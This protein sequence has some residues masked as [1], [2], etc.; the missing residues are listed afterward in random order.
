M[1]ISAAPAATDCS[2]SAMRRGRG[3]RPAGKPVE[4]AATGIPLPRKA[5]TAGAIIS[6]YTQTAPTVIGG[7]PNASSVAAATGCRA[8]AHRRPTR[9]AVSSPDRVVRSMQVTALSS[10]AA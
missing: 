5:S 1:S 7:M 10:H 6:W 8:L 3:D 4:T 9:R 2:I